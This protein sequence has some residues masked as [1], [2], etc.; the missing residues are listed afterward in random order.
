MEF[1]YALLSMDESEYWFNYDVDYEKESL[2]S[3]RYNFKTGFLLN[4][5]K[6]E[7]MVLLTALVSSHDGKTTYVKNGIRAIYGIKPFDEVVKADDNEHFS[8]AAPGLME[9]FVSIAIGAVRGFMVKNLKGTPLDKRVMPL[10]PMGDIK[11]V[12]NMKPNKEGCENKKE[13]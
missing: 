13:D 5:E 3:L 1:R 8:V 2:D 12:L 6:E 10:I 7:V 11:K 9:T 4:Q